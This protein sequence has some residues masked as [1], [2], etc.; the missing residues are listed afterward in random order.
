MTVYFIVKLSKYSMK[1][2]KMLNFLRNSY[3]IYIK[4]RKKK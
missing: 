3:I 2:N 4:N 1:L